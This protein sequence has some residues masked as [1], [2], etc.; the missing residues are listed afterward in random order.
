MGKPPLGAGRFS[1]SRVDSN[2]Q[3]Q[4]QQQKN[5]TR[6][7]AHGCCL[8]ALL[9]LWHYSHS[10]STAA[11]VTCSEPTLACSQSHANS[12]AHLSTFHISSRRCSLCWTAAR[13]I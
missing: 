4:R 11:A 12:L 3:N 10:Q 6:R 7:H 2:Q 8:L 9:V 1:W 13:I 5:Y